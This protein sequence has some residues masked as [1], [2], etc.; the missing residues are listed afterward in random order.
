MRINRVSID[1]DLDRFGG[2]A[3]VVQTNRGSFK[4]PQRALTSSE[5]Q[6]KAKLP[7]EP[8]LNNEVSEIVGQFYGKNWDSFMNTNGS[9][10]SRLRTLEFFSDKMTYTLRRFYPQLPANVNVDDSAIKQ[11]RELQIMSNLDFVS[12]P[13]LPPALRDFEQLSASFAEGV[14]SERK[15]PLVYLDMELE[16]PVFQARFRALLELSETGLIHSIGLVYRPIRKFIL[17]YRFLWENRE[18]EVFLQMSN[19]TREFTRKIG[20]STMHLLQKW[21]IDSFSVRVG[22]YFPPKN[23]DKT[24]MPKSEALARA[25]RLDPEPLVFRGFH[26]WGGGDHPLNCACPICQDMTVD[27]FISSY[28]SNK[29]QYPGQ[30][31]NAANRLH[32]YY[33]SSEEFKIAREY[34]RTGELTEYFQEKDGLNKSDVPQ[35]EVQR[36]QS[37]FE[38]LF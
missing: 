31:F 5:F 19:V 1:G 17:N 2:R 7:F 27:D 11:L 28:D 38:S 13:N 37:R 22:K 33:R 9:F 24:E 8:A 21:G 6:Y 23:G 35:P 18:A 12:I 20:A 3:L 10:D 25:K 32:E 4:T 29:E 36:P 26:T 14:L 34:I 16:P 15:E 30:T